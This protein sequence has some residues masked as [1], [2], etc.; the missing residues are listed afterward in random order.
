MRPRVP[1][2][3]DAGWGNTFRVPT[4]FCTIVLLGRMN[5]LRGAKTR[6]QCIK[7]TT[8]LT[9]LTALHKVGN[10]VLTWSNSREDIPPKQALSKSR[11]N[12]FLLRVKLSLIVL[13]V[14]CTWS[15]LCRLLKGAHLAFSYNGHI[16]LIHSS[17]PRKLPSRQ[18]YVACYEI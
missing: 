4:V 16:A 18:S 7:Q 17:V 10:K 6:T 2:G 12:G 5:N 11:A 1:L 3:L 14:V 8:I 15:T 13:D 9:E